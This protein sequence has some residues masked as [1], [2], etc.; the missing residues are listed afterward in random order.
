MISKKITTIRNLI[1]SLGGR[2]TLQND[3]HLEIKFENDSSIDF[4]IWFVERDENQTFAEYVVESQK[5][6][7]PLLAIDNIKT[8]F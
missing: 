6:Y 3:D 1:E 7:I 4:S 5:F 2:V 8:L